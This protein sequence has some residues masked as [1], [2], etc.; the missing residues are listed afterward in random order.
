MDVLDWLTTHRLAQPD[1]TSCGSAV[2]V[3]A[4]ALLDPVY[5]DSLFTGSGQLP[6]GPDAVRR[7]FA[8][9]V[10]AM[11]RLTNRATGYGGRHQL[12]W[13][14]SLG[15][16]PTTLAGTLSSLTPEGDRY[17]TILLRPGLTGG[18]TE[19]RFELL[20]RSVH[21][22]LP[23]PLYTGTHLL[24][25][26]VVLAVGSPGP[27]VLSVYEPSRGTLERLNRDQFTGSQTLDLAGWSHL[28]FAILPAPAARVGWRSTGG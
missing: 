23:C 14:R 13:P 6:D 12:P 26:H 17:H 10:S 25:R 28:W 18:R 16:L 27:G 20:A 15:T 21:H 2:A 1:A 22:G 9:D 5:R 3:L 8:S 24:P 19:R 4:Y 11:H 7:R